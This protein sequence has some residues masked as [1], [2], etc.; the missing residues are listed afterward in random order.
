MK[1][2]KAA[3]LIQSGVR[4]LIER[5]N[6]LRQRQLIIYLQALA[7]AQRCYKKYHLV[8][9]VTLFIQRRVRANM[10]AK[11]TRREFLE[12]KRAVISLQSGYRG[13]KSRYLV[14][15]LKAVLLVQR[16]FRAKIVARIVRAEYQKIKNATLLVQAAYRGYCGR[17][18]A[19][20][21]RAVRI[22]LSLDLSTFGPQNQS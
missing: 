18:M 2:Q 7:R 17:M 22:S 10:V 4:G 21:I 20:K 5:R 11:N 1:K 12:T 19:R 6:Y 13:W 3:I 8:K 9:N 15:R 14:C 16:W